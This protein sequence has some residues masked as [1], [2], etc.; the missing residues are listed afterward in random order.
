MSNYIMYVRVSLI[1]NN[2]KNIK[3]HNFNA[4]HRRSTN[5]SDDNV[6]MIKMR[7]T[8][9]VKKR[10]NYYYFQS[11]ILVNLKKIV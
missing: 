5:K 9:Y 10:E 11:R 1:S 8:E 3:E 6:L 7:K 2:N 4:Y